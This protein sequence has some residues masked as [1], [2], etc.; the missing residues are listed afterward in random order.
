MAELTIKAQIR[1]NL[2]KKHAKNY[3]NMGLIPAEYYSSQENNIHL[4]LQGKDFETLFSHAHGLISLNV[5]NTKKKYNCVIKDVQQDPVLGHV[6][7]VDLQGVKMGEK[8][9][10]NVP[11]VL[12]G[13]A[14]GVKAGG[15]L[16]HLIRELEVECLPK[17]IPNRLEID[18]R[19]LD[20]GDAV[21]VRDLQFE[22]IK[23]LNEPDEAV[24]IVEHSRIAKEEEEEEAAELLE[25]EISEPELIRSKKEEE[26]E[27]E[28]GEK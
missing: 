22:N 14:A 4:L 1:E 6:L 17:D 23:I 2:G 3:R 10:I 16:E 5:E 25:E 21:H 12:Q 7:H 28:E 19:D 27:E 9:I 13:T 18:I 11:V 8:L 15:I 26:E 20:I 24:L